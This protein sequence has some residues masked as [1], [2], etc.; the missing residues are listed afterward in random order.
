[1]RQAIKFLLFALL[2]VGLAFALCRKWGTIPAFG[3]LLNP[4]TGL[5]RNCE[6]SD[7]YWSGDHDLQGLQAP[8]TVQYDD[9]RVPH[10]FAENDHD[11]YFM[12]G[13]VT[14]R[15]RLFQME[16][17]TYRAAGR[18][19]EVLGNEKLIKIDRMNRRMGMLMSAE[20][21]LKFVST[22]SKMMGA[23]EAYAEGVN[24][25]TQNLAPQ[26]LPFEYKLMG[27][28][29]EP[30]TPLKSLLMS[31]LMAL[32][33]SG[34][35]DDLKFSNAVSKVGRPMFDSLFTEFTDSLDPIIPSGTPWDFKAM[36][37][38][39][40]AGYDPNVMTGKLLYPDIN[41]NNGSNNWAVAPSK[42]A[43]GYAML[44]NDPHLNL[45][46]PSIW[47]EVQLTGPDHSVYGVSLPGAPTIIIGFNQKIAWG[48]TNSERDVLDWYNIEFKDETQTEYK[49][50][51]KWVACTIKIEEIKVKGGPSVFDT[52]SYTQHGPVMYDASFTEKGRPV[53][54]ALRWTAHD[55][56]NELRTFY[57]LNRA[58]SHDE[59][60]EALKAFGCPGQNF[61]FASAAGDIAITQNG[62]FPAKWPGQG[63]FI[64]DGSDLRHHWQATIPWEQNPY[65]KNPTRGFVSSA[66]QIPVDS[67]YPFDVA[68]KYEMYRNRR[69]N[70]VLGEERKFTPNDMKKLQQDAHNLMAAEVLPALLSLLDRSKLSA[71]E[72]A[73]V[74]DLEAWN[75]QADTALTAP[76]VFEAWVDSIGN[77]MW[78]DDFSDPDH[79]MKHPDPFVSTQ[80]VMHRP[81]HPL[82][83][84]KRTPEVEDAK[85]IVNKAFKGAAAQLEE[86]KSKQGKDWKWSSFRNLRILH[87]A[88]E[89]LKAFGYTEVPA[90]GNH[91]CVNANYDTHGPSWRMVVELGPEPRAWGIFPGGSSGNPGSRFY[92]NAVMDW[93]RGVYYP[94]HFWKAGVAAE[95][96]KSTETFK[97]KAA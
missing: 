39:T 60:R 23:L 3:P 38:D 58:T 14:A 90:N 18:L 47:Y 25:Y 28:Q 62:A 88:G 74:K 93:A 15:D 63:R 43:S 19:T 56:S 6:S 79:P 86:W 78:D 81:L 87:L 46:L 16:M 30:W 33:L 82:M 50:N 61:V 4:S 51:G 67:L 69:I 26:D 52:V 96:V 75:L 31:K 71:G 64:L 7:L 20:N 32:Q 54:L 10:I 8:V 55:A 83:D 40:P 42:S 35:S 89:S 85:A 1:M 68:G 29:P 21:A 5:W 44:C 91:N 48:V 92:D 66:N 70:S 49:Y 17:S 94:L 37:L 2:T 72:Q 34:Y 24:A 57:Q 77:L 11:L 95:S 73:L 36:K 22:D 27:I 53:N 13:Y 84:D 45:T 97:P 12:Q 9:R 80:L 41:P 59:Y 65:I 76:S